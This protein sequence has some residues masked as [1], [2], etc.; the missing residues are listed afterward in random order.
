MNWLI[1]FWHKYSYGKNVPWA[2]IHIDEKTGFISISNWNQEY[3]KIISE[4]LPPDLISAMLDY[5]IVKLWVDRYNLKLEAPKLT[6]VHGKALEDST[7][8]LDISW[9]MAFITQLRNLGFNGDS[10]EDIVHQY[11][12]SISNSTNLKSNQQSLYD[13]DELDEVLKE[14]LLLAAKQAAE[15]QM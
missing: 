14:E 4:K 12:N 15:K 3:I 6:V 13:S 10:D 1:A 9:N 11:L 5:E 2:K 7:I 8:E